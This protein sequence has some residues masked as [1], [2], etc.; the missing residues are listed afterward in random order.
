MDAAPPSA[1][2]L[3]ELSGEV[4]EVQ[5]DPVSHVLEDAVR[6]GDFISPF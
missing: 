2:L 3:L 5:V 1:D 6:G 4:R